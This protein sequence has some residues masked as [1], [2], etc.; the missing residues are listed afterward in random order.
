[1]KRTLVIATVILGAAVGV[2]RVRAQSQE[3][4]PAAPAA[5]PTIDQVLDNYVKALGGKAA[6]EKITSRVGKGTLELPS[7]GISAS[8]EMFAKAPN[9][10]ATVIDVPGFGLVQEGFNGTVAWAQDP[11]SGLREKTGRELAQTK[12]DNDFYRD[13]RL[14]ELYAKL[15]VKGKEKVNGRDAVVVV[16]IP[17]EG[18]PDTMYFDAETW[19]LI[20]SDIERENPMGK[21]QVQV[22][23]SDY[24]E[25]DGLKTPFS[26]RQVGGPVGEVL[27][28]L[29]EIKHNVPIDDAK[30]NKPAAQ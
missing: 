29:T 22:F 4:K 13:L 10:S 24:R 2:A 18:S 5:L 20:R 25:V 30:F 16:G 15:E 11:Q 23:V 9:K 26:V 8:A 27:I 3:V 12:L 7:M 28:K 1:M 21:V 17:A 19:L 14:K 6:I